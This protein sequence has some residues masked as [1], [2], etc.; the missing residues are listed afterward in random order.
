MNF[1]FFLLLDITRKKCGNVVK[2]TEK[3]NIHN[4]SVNSL[5][6]LSIHDTVG[7]SQSNSL[8]SHQ[9]ITILFDHLVYVSQISPISLDSN[10]KIKMLNVSSTTDGILFNHIVTVSLN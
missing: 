4:C 9:P 3:Q 2:L 1:I 5:S 6:T 10:N 7:R 8:I